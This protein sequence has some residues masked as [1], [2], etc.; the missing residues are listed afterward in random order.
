MSPRPALRFAPWAALLAALLAPGWVPVTRADV[1]PLLLPP[2]RDTTASIESPPAPLLMPGRG[3]AG[4]TA[5]ITKER[6]AREQYAIGRGLE[7]QHADAA[8]IAAYRNASRLDPTLRGPH[9]HMGRLFAAV[10]Q[11]TS[12]VAEFAAE[13]TLDPS[14]TGAARELGRSLAHVG[15]STSAMRQLELLT[16]RDAKDAESWKALGFVYGLANRPADAERALRR[17]LAL[18]G[19]DAIAWRDLGVV[20]AEQGR[21]AAARAAYDTA[22]ALAPR[23]GSALVNLGNLEAREQRWN[24]AL[25]AYRGAER[26]DSLLGLA[27][28]GQVNA[29]RELRRPE[30]AGAVYRRWLTVLPD[31][32][33]TRMEAIRFF[34]AMD[35]A[36]IALELARDGVR[37]NPRSG[38]AHFALATALQA[39]GDIAGTLA[40]L[41]KAGRMLPQAE[42]RARI[43]TMIASMRA[44]APDSLRTVYTADSLANEVPGAT[45]PRRRE[46]PADSAAG[47]R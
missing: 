10:G 19:R 1:T 9:F 6:K 34:N 18:D 33:D 14:N 23:D 43:G 27:Y 38:E 16:R 47:R 26:R 35:R 3:A 8:A 25:E 22:A 28:R 24:A 17:A 4:D 45:V 44:R 13:V 46:A 15:D 21:P 36:D 29:L 2:R 42:Q 12:A 31:D 37:A 30:E 20:L 11:H 32:P 39:N 5:R 41:R 7:D 40:E